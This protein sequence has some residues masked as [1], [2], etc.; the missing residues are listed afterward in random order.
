MPVGVGLGLTAA[1]GVAKGILGGNAANN[2]TKAAQAAQ[3]QTLDW[4]KGVYGTAQTGLDP[5]ITSGG[6]ATTEL[7]GLLG[8]GGNPA[9]A[10]KAWDTY[11]NSTNY[12]FQL[13]Q[14]LQG[15]EYA[16]A[17][18]FN[19]SATAK[20]LN[21]YAQGVAGNALQ[22]Y[23]GLLTGQQSLGAQSAAAL[24]GIG[25]Q[26]GGII[27]NATQGTAS[28]IG[29]AGVY[30]ATGWGNAINDLTKLGGNFLGQ[31]SY[32]AGGGASSAFSGVDNALTGSANAI[33]GIPTY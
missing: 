33:A 9:E 2:A 11:R 32:G 16:N 21:N 25:M 22:G 18:S 6:N 30:G 26:G 23:E 31:S 5:Y 14:G 24:G 7:Q 17:P 1:G 12:Q 15:V 8:T 3:K 4:V 10:A 28:T 27:N 13:D 29:Q 19:S 20:A